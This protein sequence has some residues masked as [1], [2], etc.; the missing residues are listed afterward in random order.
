ML[1]TFIL[2]CGGGIGRPE[3]HAAAHTDG[4]DLELHRRRPARRRLDGDGDVLLDDVVGELPSRRPWAAPTT[5]R[6]CTRRDRWLVSAWNGDLEDVGR[7]GTR[8]RGRSQLLGNSAPSSGSVTHGPAAVD[9]SAELG[10]RRRKKR[11][12]RRSA[13]WENRCTARRMHPG[14]IV[15]A[16]GDADYRR[17]VPPD[18]LEPAAPGGFASLAAPQPTPTTATDAT[19]KYPKAFTFKS[20]LEVR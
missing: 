10:R 9:G 20:F 15:P 17:R 18:P 12:D 3:H 14:C 13:P 8:T 1:S 4:R 5:R 11:R 16:C 7:T 19:S 6:S 2:R